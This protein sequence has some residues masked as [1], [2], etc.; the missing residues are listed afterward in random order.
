MSTQDPLIDAWTEYWRTGQAASCTHAAWQPGFA[1]QWRTFFASQTD[2]ACVLDVATGNG[3]VLLHAA[4][5]RL[6]VTGIDAA[7]I[8]PLA[9]THNEALRDVLF[10]GGVRIEHLPFADEAFDAV[11]SQFGF[12][13]A[14]EERACIE[15]ARVLRPCGAIRLVMHSKAGAVWRDVADRTERLRI[16]LAPDGVLT[17]LNNAATQLESKEA[18]LAD[19]LAR[20]R[21]LPGEAAPDDAATFYVRGLLRIWLARERYD[22]AGVSHAVSDA[23]SRARAVFLRQDAMLCAAH[24]APDMERLRDRFRDAGVDTKAPIPILDAGGEQIAWQLD[25]SRCTD[26]ARERRHHELEQEV[27]RAR[28]ATGQ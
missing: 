14:E 22:A 28:T 12:E 19:A 18:D 6:N 13:Y 11:S 23:V 8:D 2:G 3:A 5:T 1:A 25:G 27:Q 15:V 7:D 26:S 17:R 4:S 24:S 9:H 10:L 20:F 16:V 21:A